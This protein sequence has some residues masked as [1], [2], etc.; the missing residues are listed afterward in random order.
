MKRNPFYAISAAAMLAGC[1]MLSEALEMRPGQLRGV[2]ITIGVL[3]LYEGLL[4]ALGTYLIAS[5]RA[6]GAK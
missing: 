5:K 2:L 4:V 6:A 1:F 3:Q